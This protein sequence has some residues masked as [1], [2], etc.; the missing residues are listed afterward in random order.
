MV[1]SK[2]TPAPSGA[3]EGEAKLP[4]R[5]VSVNAWRVCCTDLLISNHEVAGQGM[6]TLGKRMT[7]AYQVQQEVIGMQARGRYRR[8]FCPLLKVHDAEIRAQETPANLC[9][10]MLE[11]NKVRTKLGFFRGY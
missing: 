4:R 7:H 11:V 3:G 5:P 10:S 9:F 2:T 1:F 8:R 6:Q